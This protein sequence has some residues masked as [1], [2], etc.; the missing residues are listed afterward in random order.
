MLI[1]FLK[2]GRGIAFSSMFAMKEYPADVLP[3]Y[4]QGHSL[5]TYFI[6]QGGKAKY[7]QFLADG[8]Q[9]EDWT[10]AV[11]K[12]YGFADLAQLQNTWLEWVRSGSRPLQP[13]TAGDQP[14]LLASAMGPVPAPSQAS[15]A[16]AAPN[17]PTPPLNAVASRSAS[18]DIASDYGPNR[19]CLSSNGPRPAKDVSV[20]DR[21]RTSYTT[22][23]PTA[24]WPPVRWC[25]CN[26]IR[27][28]Q[29]RRR[30]APFQTTVLRR[31]IRLPQRPKPRPARPTLC[32]PA[33]YT[34]A[35]CKPVPA[36]RKRRKP[37]DRSC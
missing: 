5:A 4:A 21:R 2:T 30:P 19:K 20:R 8:M 1:Q 37:Q 23:R 34:R 25:R 7:L 3:L 14:I 12:H 28:S 29:A 16:P 24:R 33:E 17:L 9:D 32:S 36:A 35:Q 27:R 18:G 22:R 13:T 26:S 31:S 15:V 10:A 6:G 11:H